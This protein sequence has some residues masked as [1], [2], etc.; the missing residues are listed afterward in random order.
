MELEN[1]SPA[2]KYTSE[3]QEGSTCISGPSSGTPVQYKLYKR[4][5][6]GCIGIVSLFQR[7]Y[8]LA[9]P[10]AILGLVEWRHGHELALVR[11]HIE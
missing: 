11:T 6:A 5:F 3:S 2:M 7:K 10:N 4:R 9:C 8:H 1:L